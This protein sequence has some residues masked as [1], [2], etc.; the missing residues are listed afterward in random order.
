MKPNNKL[1]GILAL[2]IFCLTATGIA[3][4]T[5]KVK[6]T[7]QP[8]QRAHEKSEYL[9]QKTSGSKEA[10]IDKPVKGCVFKT[11]FGEEKS[12]S[13]YVYKTPQKV[14]GGLQEGLQWMVKAQNNDGGWGAGS[15]YKQ[16]VMDPHAVQSDPATTAM[17]AMALLRCKNTTTSGNYSSQLN[18]ALKFLL[19]AVENSPEKE[20]NITTLK[21]TQPQIKLGAN[22]DVI[23]TS[24]F[25]TNI[26]DN[27]T[28]DPK[29]AN[30]V[31]ESI[32][33]CVRKIQ[34]AQ[35]GNGSTKGSG[36]AGV[37]QS[38]FANNALE[39]AQSK[40]AAVDVEALEKSRQF[41]K[42][43]F[44]AKSKK[45]N[46][47]MGAGVVLYSVS[48]SARAS[49][50][51]AREARELIDQA[52]REG[53]MD[54][55]AEINVDNLRKA[56]ISESRAMKLA[57]AYDINVAAADMAQQ[58]EVISGFGNNGGEE[59][60]SFLQT[61]EGMIIAKDNGWKKWYDNTSGRLLSIQN[62][63]GSWNGHH[64]IT[65]PVFCTATC[66]LVLSINNDI[67]KLTA[68]IK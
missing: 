7:E 2:V 40:G 56:G 21:G 23:L 36:W 41:Q 9:S 3:A 12:D 45:V 18:K 43:N 19:E 11:V 32:N 64:C 37:L 20:L 63:D 27:L 22:I 33:K 44:D 67:E 50:S 4:F 46:T 38:S 61:G 30:R 62:Q 10:A 66:L 57:T 29:L 28:N 58:N 59:F 55:H 34:L 52:K 6:S 8:T 1:V 15:H 60:L 25:L 42:D 51:E 53:K 48:G 5:F 65:S 35:T 24:Q 31:K 17:V 47:E 16:D 13:F 26:S 54:K 49:A 14:F 68:S 39:S